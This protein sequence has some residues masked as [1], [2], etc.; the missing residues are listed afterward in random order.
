MYGNYEHPIDLTHGV[1][2]LS[3]TREGELSIYKRNLDGETKERHIL[4]PAGIVIHPV[5]P[6]QTPKNLTPCLL[7]EFDREISLPPKGLQPFFLTFPVEIGVF[8]SA[9]KQHELLDVF[10]FSSQKY[11][12]YGDPANGTLC[13]YW[14]TTISAEQPNLD[15]L[16]TGILKLTIQNAAEHW[17]TVRQAVFKATGM[18]LFF[19]GDMVSM[20]ARM[21]VLGRKLAETEF[22]TAPLQKGMTKAFKLLEPRTLYKPRKFVMEGEV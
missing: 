11:T 14:K 17:V 21:K 10:A 22:E 9:G 3:L 4:G 19:S 2:S 18:N 7:L 13:K 6:V 1:L 15:P 20:A 8:V 16:R 12:L 5:E